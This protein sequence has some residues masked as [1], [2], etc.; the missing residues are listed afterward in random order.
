M[1]KPK[2]RRIS[3]RITEFNE[4]EYLFALRHYY[5]LNFENGASDQS[6]LVWIETL[7]KDEQADLS[8]GNNSYGNLFQGEK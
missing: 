7:I 6:F 3:K 4:L 1:N 2:V 8:E 5:E